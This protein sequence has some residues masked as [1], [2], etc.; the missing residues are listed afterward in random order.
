MTALFDHRLI[1]V[2]GK[3][4]VGR[5]TVAA[6]LGVAAAREGRRTCVIELSGLSALPPLFGLTGRTFEYRR[7]TDGLWVA[8][9][10]VSECL[11]DFARRK[12]RVSGLVAKLFH[13]AAV[14]AFIDAIP[15]LHDLL[16]LGKVENLINEPM[17]EDPRFDLVIIDAPA[18]GHG[19]TL[20]SAARTMT[21]VAKA[22]PFHDLASNIGRFLADPGLTAVAVVTL[23]EELPVSETLELLDALAN[24]G[25]PAHSILVNR[26]DGAPLPEP[27]PDDLS[28]VL[29][30]L[31][32]GSSLRV[33]AEES[34]RRWTAQQR[35]VAT[36]RVQ[37]HL[38]VQ[39][40]PRAK[41]PRLAHE[42]GAALR[43]ETSR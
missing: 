41:G 34:H 19:I 31:E 8:S 22:G 40:L 28:T 5:T 23:P 20:L 35:A 15:G 16:Q 11:E 7:A 37:T 33:L 18:T 43:E 32:G 17:A 26:C 29:D 6:A 27:L 42:L 36:L 21:Q 38:P 2:T 14:R 25:L 1:V 10:T 12:L 13:T 3:G 39:L 30:T 24:E 4:G 9:L